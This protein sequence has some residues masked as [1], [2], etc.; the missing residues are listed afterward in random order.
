M[1]ETEMS[2]AAYVQA[3]YW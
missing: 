1:T 2:A 3:W